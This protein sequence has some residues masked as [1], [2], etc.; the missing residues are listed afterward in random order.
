MNTYD[1]ADYIVYVRM[2]RILPHAVTSTEPTQHRPRHLV[3][4]FC[5]N[6]DLADREV[7]GSF[8]VALA[9]C[10][11]AVSAEPLD[12]LIIRNTVPNCER[13]NVIGV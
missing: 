6:H 10:E 7:I 2:D 13:Y 1:P 9:D 3:V 5:G 4:S 11:T 12:D 8:N